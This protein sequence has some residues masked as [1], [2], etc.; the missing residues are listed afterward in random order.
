MT[1][2]R[3]RE[4]FCL[5]KEQFLSPLIRAS[6]A[7]SPTRGEGSLQSS[8]GSYSKAYFNSKACFMTKYGLF[9]G[10]GVCFIGRCHPGC[11][12]PLVGEGAREARMRGNKKH[13]QPNPHQ[14]ICSIILHPLLQRNQS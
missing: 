2:I 8:S 10:N 4:V 7:P 1:F 11:P 6:R 9:H 13:F 12:S 14:P 3:K 5:R